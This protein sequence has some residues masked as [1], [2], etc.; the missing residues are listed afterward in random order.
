MVGVWVAERVVGVGVVAQVLA[1]E[2]AI[3]QL[4]RAARDGAAGGV[5]PPPAG[6][7]SA[8]CFVGGVVVDGEQ[9]VGDHRVD[10][11]ADR[12]RQDPGRPADGDE[13]E[14]GDEAGEQHDGGPGD[15]AAVATGHR[16]LFERV[17][18]LRRSRR[19]RA[20]RA[21]DGGW[22]GEGHGQ[23][24]YGTAVRSVNPQLPAN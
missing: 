24:R 16:R 13:H 4:Q 1:G 10:G 18:S 9:D 11:A 21:A 20:R 8:D 14:A 22:L 17:A 19:A 23:R 15:E 2:P 7:P 5:E 12:W 3:A 6:E